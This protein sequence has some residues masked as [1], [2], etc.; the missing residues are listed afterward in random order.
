MEDCLQLGV[1]SSGFYVRNGK[2]ADTD[3]IRAFM[4]QWEKGL[5]D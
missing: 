1:M 3:E 2:S 4:E 5:I